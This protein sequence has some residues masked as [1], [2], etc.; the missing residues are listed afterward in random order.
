M[1][2]SQRVHQS[3]ALYFKDRYKSACP[4]RRRFKSIV[5]QESEIYECLK[6]M[7]LF[8]V[9]CHLAESLSKYPWSSFRQRVLG[10]TNG[11]LD[12]LI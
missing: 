12:S 10:K 5:L 2:F 7:E 4:L 9:R 6:C 3:Y 11:V 8:P 1:L